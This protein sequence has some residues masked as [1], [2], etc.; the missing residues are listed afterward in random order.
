MD[1]LRA[2][3]L[4]VKQGH[5]ASVLSALRRRLYADSVALGLRRDLAKPFKAPQPKI[6]VTIRPLADAE[7]VVFTDAYSAS[8]SP[9][10]SGELMARIRMLEAGIMTCYAA[11]DSNN[12]ICY[13]QWLIK[14]DDNSSIRNY[15]HG[16]VPLLKPNEALVEGAYAFHQFR[17]LGIMPYAMARIA[18]RAAD[19]GA[20]WVV[21]FVGKDNVPSLKGCRLAGFEP[22]LIRREYRRLLQRK[23]VFE[24]MGDNRTGSKS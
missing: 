23:F 1:D 20:K 5:A 14:S 17:G 11:V 18:E 15:F 10:D 6:P 7:H 3:G 19:C 8:A 21:T 22:Y 4:L 12:V 2:A 9:S 13:V 24:P 16:A